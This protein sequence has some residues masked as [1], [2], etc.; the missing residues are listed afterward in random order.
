MS[1]DWS[2][3]DPVQY[4][5]QHYEGKVTSRSELERK[6]K[7]L[8]NVLKARKLLD[9][10]LADTQHH[11]RDWDVGDPLKYFKQHYEGKIASR[12]EL[13]RK[14]KGLYIVLGKRRLLD[15][16]LPNQNQNYR[17]WNTSDPVRYFEQHYKGRIVNRSDLYKKD[18]VLYRTLS[19]RKL[20]DKVLPDSHQS[21]RDWNCTDP[22]KYFERHYKGKITSRAELSEKDRMLYYVLRKRKLLDKVL[23]DYRYHRDWNSTDAVQYFKQHHEGKVSGRSELSRKDPYLYNRLRKS[24]KLDIIFPKPDEGKFLEDLLRDY[25]D[26]DKLGEVPA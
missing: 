13:E 17:D 21:Y 25:V 18:S 15:Q 4:F 3:I 19:V 26:D 22:I 20:L 16:I 12:S 8:Y 23:P 2:Q 6:D 1:R 14:D 9:K 11:Y 5:Q 24:G 7:G 10:V